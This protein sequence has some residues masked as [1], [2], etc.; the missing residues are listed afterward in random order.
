MQQWLQH[1][2]MLT[3]SLHLLPCRYDFADWLSSRVNM[4]LSNEAGQSQVM[5]DIDIKGK[6]WN[7]QVKLGTP[8][9]LGESKRSFT[10]T[11]ARCLW[12]NFCVVMSVYA[13]G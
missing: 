8:Q 5:G 11:P 10:V 12:L 4:Q 6:D 1:H 13:N 3:V 7:G 2:D 9:F